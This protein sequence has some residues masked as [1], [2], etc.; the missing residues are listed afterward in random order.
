MKNIGEKMR[1]IRKS[2]KPEYSQKRIAEKLGISRS[3]YSRYENGI[4]VPSV[5]IVTALCKVYGI[6][7]DVFMF[8]EGVKSENENIAQRNKAKNKQ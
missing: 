1:I 2:F 4:T 7:M 8:N 3:T 5:W 6:D